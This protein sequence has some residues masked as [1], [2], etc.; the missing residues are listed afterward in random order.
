MYIYTIMQTWC[1]IT[2]KCKCTRGDFIRKRRPTERLPIRSPSYELS[3]D[4]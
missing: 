1:I 2:Y 3:I 4:P